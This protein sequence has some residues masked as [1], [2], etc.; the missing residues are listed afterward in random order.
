MAFDRSKFKKVSV[1][2]IDETLSEAQNTMNRFGSQGGRAS[3]L[4]LAK[5]G[6]YEIRVLPSKSGRPYIPRKTVKLPIEC[7]VLDKD[8]KDTGKKEVR[9]KDIFTSDIHSDRMEGKDAV[10]TYID[11][12]ERKAAQ[13]QD[14]DERK[15]FRAPITGYRKG[16]KGDWVWGISP[17]LNYVA[18]VL[19]EGEI[20]RMDIR[21]QWWKTM[22]SISLERS[23]ETIQIDVFS[24]YETGYPLIVN[25]HKDSGKSVY[26]ISCG[27]PEVGQ[28]WDDFFEATKV[29]KS[30]LDSLDEL[31]T[32]D[33]Q[34]IDVFS[35]R[36]WDLQL[37]GLKRFDEQ[38]GFDIF[39]E[40]E[41]L[42]C[43]ER[44]EA[45]VPEVEDVKKTS[46][47]TIEE[48]NEEEERPSKPAPKPK[49]KPATTQYP[50]LIK[51]K[52]E[53]RDYIETEYEGT[54]TLPDLPV[55]EMRKW[56][57][58]MKQG[59]MLPFDQYKEEEPEP[60]DEMPIE[61]EVASKAKVASES[62]REK[63]AKLRVRK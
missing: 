40:D 39:A 14:S 15:K 3:F 49:E 11:F 56:Y 63:L 8:G 22:K 30:I 43:L 36:D 32:L 61:K 53:L 48:D 28:N 24:D 50:P 13:I 18:Y 19:Y 52:A 46:D 16:G 10:L 12:V 58:L 31:P 44:I 45:M 57:D 62:V 2:T 17:V 60:Q 21:P 1:G 51:M 37:E 35:R 20:Y 25:Y 34:Y 54:E 27:L 33:D 59:M 47:N 55:V 42:D 9:M 7:P 26:D 4:S 23:K 41:F 38:Y 5:E 29:P 6:R